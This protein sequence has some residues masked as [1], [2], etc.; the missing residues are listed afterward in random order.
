[1][2]SGVS[3]FVAT[4]TQAVPNR[5]S[6]TNAVPVSSEAQRAAASSPIQQNAV[7]ALETLQN[8]QNRQEQTNAE[9]LTEEEQK[10]V[11]ELKQ[12]DQKVRA[13]EQAHK[14]VAGPYAGAISYETVTGP[15]GQ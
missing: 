5:V 15:D 8:A 13:H 12:T 11:D 14:N 6:G 10:V 7:Q 2:V 1:M 9:G 4:P 3:P